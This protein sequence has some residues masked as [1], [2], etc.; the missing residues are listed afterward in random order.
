M[1]DVSSR[2]PDPRGPPREYAKRKPVT[3]LG[4]FEDEHATAASL[5]DSHERRE[6]AMQCFARYVAERAL[7]PVE[8][9]EQD[10][11]AE[12]FSRGC[13]GGRMGAGVW[14]RYRRR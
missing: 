6:L 10:W 2:N 5:M 8:Y 13:Y 11:T 12:E 3:V 9:I 7:R 1:S 4:F 14:T